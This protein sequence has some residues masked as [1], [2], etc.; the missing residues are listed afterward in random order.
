MP[1]PVP[2]VPETLLVFP[3][4]FPI[5]VMGATRP[6]FAQTILAMVMRHA[7]DFDASTVEMRSSREGRYV[8]LTFTI[9]ATSREQLDEIYRDLCDHPMV[10]MV[11]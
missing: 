5:K 4:E 11:L 2:S 10:A 6:E 8:S 1:D 7:P 3:T 9:C